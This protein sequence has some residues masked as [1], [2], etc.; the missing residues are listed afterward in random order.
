[1][2]AQIKLIAQLGKQTGQIDGSARPLC[3][4]DRD[5]TG[6]KALGFVGVTGPQNALAVAKR[7]I[8]I[9]RWCV[10]EIEAQQSDA[11]KEPNRSVV[12]RCRLHFEAH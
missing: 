9:A 11:A 3:V 5:E 7:M 10:L 6:P 4:G 2:V 1:M 12:T 8:L